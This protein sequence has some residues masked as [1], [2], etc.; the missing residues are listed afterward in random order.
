M[1]SIVKHPQTD[2]D[3]Y[4]HKPSFFAKFTRKCT[5][6]ILLR[7]LKKANALSP[8]QTICELGGANSCFFPVIRKAFPGVLFTVVDNNEQGVSLF[9]KK[10]ANDLLINTKLLDILIDN[11]LP[12]MSDVVFSVGLIEHFSPA[13]TQNVIRKHFLCSKPGG[14]VIITFP[15]PTWLYKIIRFISEK[16]HAWIFYDERPLHVA[17]VVAQVEPYA[18]VITS[19]INWGTLLTQGVV[20]ARTKSP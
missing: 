3:S 4:Y 6:R 12:A 1:K 16:C 14:L 5:E 18:R 11:N 2:W 10:Y 13:D 8:I 17:D 7:H 19:F 15:T 20:I 9:K